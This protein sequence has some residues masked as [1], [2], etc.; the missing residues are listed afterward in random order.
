MLARQLKSNITEHAAI[1]RHQ[2]AYRQQRPTQDAV[3]CLTTTIS[4][5]IEKAASNYPKCFFLDFS[6]AF[7]TISVEY[8]FPLI[9]HRDSR[10]TGWVTSFLSNCVQQTIV[11][12]QLSAPILT[13]YS[14]HSYSLCIQTG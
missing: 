12:N 7:N 3:L 9:Q 1:D 13:M 4:N 2:F 14:H 6:S 8:I 5:S 10:V 11:N